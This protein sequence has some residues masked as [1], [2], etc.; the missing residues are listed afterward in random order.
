METCEFDQ[1]PATHVVRLYDYEETGEQHPVC[2]ECAHGI[3]DD[4]EYE[5]LEITN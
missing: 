4:G 1:Y 5:V 3:D 2:A